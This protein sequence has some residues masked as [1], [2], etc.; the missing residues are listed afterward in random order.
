MYSGE[1]LRIF[2]THAWLNHDDYLRVFEYLEEARGFRYVNCSV[3]ERPATATSVAGVEEALRRQIA[4]SE[5]VVGLA[6][7]IDGHQDLLR[8]ELSCARGLRKPVIFLPAFGH[9]L[10]LPTAYKGYAAQEIA[11]D[12]RVLVDALLQHARGVPPAR[13][14]VVE[15]KLD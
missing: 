15:F 10:A 8:F 6:T 3:T 4:A 13:W 9:D 11:W 5:I 14:D 1:P 12:G 2:V 7:L